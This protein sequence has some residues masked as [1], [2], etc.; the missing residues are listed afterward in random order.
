MASAEIRTVN[1]ND[2]GIKKMPAA[3]SLRVQVAIARVVGEPLF[4]S[5]MDAKGNLKSEDADKA[6]GNAIG[7]MTSRMD[8]DELIAVMNM[9]LKGVANGNKVSLKVDDF[10][11][12]PLD[13][14]LV[15]IEGLKVSF[16]DFLDAAR[17]RLSDVAKFLKDSSPSSPPTSTGTSGAP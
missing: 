5:L 1:G 17:S 11:G 10:D 13:L 9:V 4:R 8:A 12:R 6:F 7:L 3:D 14:W 15:F 16:G 2:Y